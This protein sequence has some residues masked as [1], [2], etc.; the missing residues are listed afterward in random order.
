MACGVRRGP[1][2]DRRA[3]GRSINRRPPPLLINRSHIFTTDPP[4][5][6]RLKRFN[7]RLNAA[8][9]R[10]GP[11]DV[12][13]TSADIDPYRPIKVDTPFKSRYRISFHKIGFFQALEGGESARDEKDVIHLSAMANCTTNYYHHRSYR[14]KM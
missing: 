14:L 12:L 11:V 9:T 8:I 5:R 1:R 10:S 2:I 4:Q 7:F 6:S 13:D 3:L